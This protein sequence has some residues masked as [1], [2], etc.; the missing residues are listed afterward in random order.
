M[1]EQRYYI[2]PREGDEF[3]AGVYEPKDR[4]HYLICECYTVEGARLVADALN[5]YAAQQERAEQVKALVE[6]LADVMRIAPCSPLGEA[7]YSGVPTKRW[8]AER[9]AYARGYNDALGE[10]KHIVRAALAPFE[11]KE[12]PNA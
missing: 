2:M 6:A 1:D 12:A 3:E 4:A 5:A 7:A 9:T 11:G 8:M 10:V